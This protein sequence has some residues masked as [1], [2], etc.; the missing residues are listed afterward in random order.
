MTY[1]D[2]VTEN[3]GDNFQKANQEI[4]TALTLFYQTIDSILKENTFPEEQTTKW[5]TMMETISVKASELKVKIE[6]KYQQMINKAQEFEDLYQKLVKYNGQSADFEEI[7]G[8]KK[9]KTTASVTSV[10]RDLEGEGYPK[11]TVSSSK[12]TYSKVF[13]EGETEKYTWGN[14]STSETK[15]YSAFFSS[16][17]ELLELSQLLASII[18]K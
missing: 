6:E 12:T 1:L 5:T 3:Y 17:V 14:A 2:E 11:I 10:S 8:D 15:S 13:A 7:V 16:S 9:I 18:S 4:D